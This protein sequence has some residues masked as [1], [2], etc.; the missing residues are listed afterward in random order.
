ME[1]GCWKTESVAKYY[2]GAISNGKGC[3]SKRTRS[4]SYANASDFSVSPR[5]RKDLAACAQKKGL[6][7]R[8]FG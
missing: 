4:Q 5:F 3:G 6:I 7:L 8:I 2:I 1:I